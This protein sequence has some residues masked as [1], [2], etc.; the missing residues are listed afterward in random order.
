MRSFFELGGGR[1]K[2]ALIHASEPTRCLPEVRDQMVRV[3]NT[4][5]TIYARCVSTHFVLPEPA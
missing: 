4:T 1:Q 5:R 2:E 3:P